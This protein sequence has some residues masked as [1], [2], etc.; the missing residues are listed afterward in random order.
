MESKEIQLLIF[1]LSVVF[2]TLL[3]F[4]IVIFFYF[5][6][7]KTAF[8]IEK[9]EN[10]MHFQSELVKTQIE[11]KDSTLSE[12]SRELH[13]NIG[14]ILSVAIMQV[15]IF[16]NTGKT[17]SAE[18]WQGLKEVLTKSLDEIR[19]LSKIINRDD[20]A[21]LDFVDAIESDFERIRRLKQ[22]D[23]S[24]TI[25][26]DVPEI[27]NEHALIIYRIFQ[28][29][30]H[31][32]LRHSHSDSIEMKMDTSASTL[33]LQLTDRGIGFTVDEKNS[34]LGMNNMKMRSDLI[35]AAFFV[36]SSSEGTKI[37]LNY[38]LLNEGQNE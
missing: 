11:I 17:I 3:V 25:K 26:G 35:G 13:D 1:T 9:L 18:E 10:E 37:T 15:N 7:K 24:F 32:V 5:Q 2:L 20:L 21:K 19:V 31:N 22:I 27:N 33:Y 28:E 4:L 38:P 6:K 14:Q 12:I 29:A 34:G 23:C 8:L 30:I 36:D 16:A